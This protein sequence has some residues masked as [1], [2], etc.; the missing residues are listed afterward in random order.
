MTDSAKP[1]LIIFIMATSEKRI[2]KN[3]IFLYIRMMVI[4][5]VSIYTSRVILQSLGASD[6]GIYNVVGGVVSMMVFLNSALNASTSRFLTYELGV[7]DL[8]Q[9]KKTFSASLNLHIIVAI[10]VLIICETI[11]LWFFYNKL[12]IPDDRMSAAL[13]VYQF[14]IITMVVSY[15]QVP[16]NAALISH[17]NMAVYAYVGLYEAVSRLLIAYAVTISPIDNLVFYGLLLMANTIAVQIFYRYYTRIKYEECQFRL[18]KDLALYKKLLSYSGWDLFGGVAGVSQNQGV[19]ILLNIFFGPTVNAARAIS[20]QVKSA[21]RT[22]VTNFLTAVRPQ[23]VKN[24]AEQQY[25]EMYNLT[26]KATRFSLYLILAMIIPICFEIH[27][28]LNLWL[29]DGYP[30]TTALFTIIILISA[31]FDVIEQ[32]NNLAFHAIG[33]IKTG[34]IICG[35]IMILSLPISYVF[36]KLGGEAYVALIIVLISNLLSIVINLIIIHGYIEF[37]YRDLILNTYLPVI[38]VSVATVLP[39]TLI[40]NYL[41]EGVLRLGLLLVVTEVVLA[42]SVYFLGM[43][44]KEKSQFIRLVKNKIHK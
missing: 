23:V 26:F 33:R 4:M 29:G 28:I 22:F 17:E 10:I 25:D 14:S 3:T 39:A 8:Q 34:N 2:A 36:L 13:W 11:G 43:T 6:Y 31:F 20:M 37:S 24:F 16:Y 38:Y 44:R 7:G 12:N 1:I 19:N 42:V 27:F 15:T 40:H 18:I 41:Q 5:V 21:V 30:E 32:G 35:S 9:L